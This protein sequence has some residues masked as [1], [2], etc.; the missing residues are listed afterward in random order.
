MLPYFIA[1]FLYISSTSPTTAAATT[2]AAAAKP[3]DV[4]D[5][6]HD[7]DNGLPA[8]PGLPN[9]LIVEQW[10]LLP[11]DQQVHFFQLARFD[12]LRYVRINEA[13]SNLSS[14]WD[15]SCFFVQCFFS[16]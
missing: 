4:L 9:H 7:G 3:E 10:N 16:G 13:K 8:R 14:A 11:V 6:G 12:Q 1:F 15:F 5:P 2:A